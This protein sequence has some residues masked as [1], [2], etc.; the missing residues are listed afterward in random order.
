MTLATCR[1]AAACLA[2]LPLQ[3]LAQ[4]WQDHTLELTP[5]IGA[6]FGGEFRDQLNAR[7]LELADSASFGL[8]FNY[9]AGPDALYDVLYS[10]QSTEL[11]TGDLFT[12]ESVVDMTVQYLQVGGTYL[13]TRDRGQPY[14]S[15]TIGAARYDPDGPGLRAENFFAATIGGGYK[16]WFNERLGLRLDGRAYVTAM[17]N[18]SDIFCRTGTDGNTCAIRVDGDVLVQWEASL[19]LV[20]AF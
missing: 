4:D 10:H 13:F 17:S 18:E 16:Y 12:G 11:E 20:F 5:Q 6:R 14:L 1:R 7:D 3:G 19:G 2:L 15:L 9:T 8:Q